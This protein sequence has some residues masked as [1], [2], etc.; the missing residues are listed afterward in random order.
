MARSEVHKAAI[1]QGSRESRAVRRYL[2]SLAN[3]PDGRRGS[4]GK[5]KARLARTEAALEKSED[6]LEQLELHQDKLDLQRRIAELENSQD[7]AN[8]EAEFIRVAKSYSERKGI[9]YAAWRQVGVPARVLKEAGIP[10]QRG[11]R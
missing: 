4:V 8:L 3:R 6:P 1:A 9:T 2:E 10:Q 7:N 11:W 5:L